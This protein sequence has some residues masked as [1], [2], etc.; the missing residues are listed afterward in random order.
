LRLCS[1]FLRLKVAQI[2]LNDADRLEFKMQ[3]EAWATVVPI[4]L[5][6]YPR[7]AKL[8]TR[9]WQESEQAEGQ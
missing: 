7:P 8:C 9:G 5:A 1:P 4:V 6:G 3:T 2:L